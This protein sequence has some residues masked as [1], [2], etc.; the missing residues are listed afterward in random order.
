M[1][2]AL[3]VKYQEMVD[4]GELRDYADIARLGYVSRA[5]ITQ[6]MNLTNL[7]PDLQEY[8][9]IPTGF[10]P[11]ERQLRELLAQIAWDDQRRS[12]RKLIKGP[13]HTPKGDFPVS[14]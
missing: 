7:A 1:L 4:R 8:L 5:R 6:I 2:M 10:L 3:A 9:L 12:W 11:P 14:T 13:S